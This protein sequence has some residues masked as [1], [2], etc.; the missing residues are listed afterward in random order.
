MS[1]AAFVELL[2]K[3]LPLA[4]SQVPSLKRSEKGAVDIKIV[5]WQQTFKKHSVLNKFV[6][7]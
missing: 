4:S 7:K 6:T 3:Q 5:W 2:K 1:P